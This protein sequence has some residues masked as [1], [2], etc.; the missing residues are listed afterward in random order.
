MRLADHTLEVFALASL[1][2]LLLIGLILVPK[3]QVRRL[4]PF[5][6][7]G[8]LFDRENEVRRTLAQVIG[9][10]A[11]VVTIYGTIQT[12]RAANDQLALANQQL[13][14]SREAQLGERFTKAVEQLG[15]SNVLVRIG[16]V[17]SLEKAALMDPDRYHWTA[18]EGFDRVCSEGQ[19]SSYQGLRLLSGSAWTTKRRVHGFARSG[20]T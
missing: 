19:R 2:L 14:L 3:L 17:L 8:Q 5:L 18:V 15:D 9:G 16:G 13:F 1:G 12:Q 4:R 6:K 11:F 10:L 7:P 20:P